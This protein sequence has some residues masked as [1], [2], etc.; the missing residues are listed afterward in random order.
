MS[1][2]RSVTLSALVN[3]SESLDSVRRL[4]SLLYVLHIHHIASQSFPTFGT[5][6]YRKLA[7]I[8]RLVQRSDGFALLIAVFTTECCICSSH[9]SRL[10]Q[11]RSNTWMEVFSM[12][13]LKCCSLPWLQNKGDMLAVLFKFESSHLKFIR[14]HK[15]D[16]IYRYT[17]K[18]R[19][20]KPLIQFSFKVFRQKGQNFV[21]SARTSAW[22]HI[23]TNFRF[24]FKSNIKSSISC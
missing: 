21:H 18:H 3:S 23:F 8:V 1:T 24:I 14:L 6:R 5:G 22:S 19:G 4:I 15:A 17:C 20:A 12:E 16:F 9:G 2:L 7:C 10:F 11:R 13:R